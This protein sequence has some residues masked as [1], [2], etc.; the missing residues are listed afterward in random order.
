MSKPADNLLFNL[1]DIFNDLLLF[2]V[3][4]VLGILIYA[5]FK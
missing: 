2:L 1:K 4:K 5:Y 3:C